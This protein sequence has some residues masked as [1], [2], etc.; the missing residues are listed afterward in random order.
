MADPYA[1]RLRPAPL[2]G[3]GGEPEWLGEVAA[4]GGVTLADA[5]ALPEREEVA[6]ARFVVVPCADLGIV[7]PLARVSPELAA[8]FL[9]AR[10]SSAGAAAAGV[11][12]E[13]QELFVV[14]QGLVAGPEDR[15]G[16]RPVDARLIAQL[17]DLALGDELGWESD[18]NIG[19]ETPVSA[20][21]FEGE[22]LE[23]LTPR[24]LYAHHD[25][26]YG[27][28]ALVPELQSV[29]HSAAVAAGAGPEVIAATRWPPVV[30]G[31]A[32]KSED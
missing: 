16:A 8:A 1:T 23:M 2:S 27:H 15:P 26:V 22:D 29:L 11:L 32:W 12:T 17:L 21:G 13:A 3:P 6:A 4:R 18:P 10:S 14:K 31:S 5:A 24:F 20:P 9:I 30:T 28:A 19:W 25:R 7:P